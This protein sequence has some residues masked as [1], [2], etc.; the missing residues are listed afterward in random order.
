VE[1]EQEYKE[2]SPRLELISK[3]ELE[4]FYCVEALRIDP[5]LMRAHFGR[6]KEGGGGGRRG[7]VEED[8]CV[9][10]WNAERML[11]VEVPQLACLHFSLFWL[12]ARL[13]A[14]R[15]DMFTR[16]LGFGV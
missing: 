2:V 9:D 13:F 8:E 11:D 10:D 1:V 14:R 12:L 4:A 6:R 7:D 16:G 5:V 15:E 3:E